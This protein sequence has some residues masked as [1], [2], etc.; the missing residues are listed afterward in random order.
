M[1]YFLDGDDLDALRIRMHAALSA[2]RAQIEDDGVLWGRDRSM[3]ALRSRLSVL[4]RG[5][6]PVILE[7]ETGTGKSYLAE[8]FVHQKSGRSGPFVVL[9]VSTVP[10]DLLAAQLFGSVRGAYT[11]AISDRKGVFELAHRGTLFL[12]EI[13]NAPLEVQKQLLLVLQDKRVRPIGGNHDR[14]VDVK[15]VAASNEPLARAVAE[16]RFRADLYMRLSPAT[17]VIIPP[18]RQRTADLRFFV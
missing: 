1:T 6:L 15:V 10:R 4:S 9:D 12:D 17:R 7:G 3:R 13:Q 8:R 5:A 18:L 2:A 11:G 16:G 14:V